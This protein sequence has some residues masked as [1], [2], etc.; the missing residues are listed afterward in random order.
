MTK[1]TL[2]I[3]YLFISFF[4]VVSLACGPIAKQ[5]PTATVPPPVQAEEPA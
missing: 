2:K 3:I 5:D 1:P 4:I